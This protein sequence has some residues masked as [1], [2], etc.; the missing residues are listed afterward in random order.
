MTP[1]KDSS[2]TSTVRIEFW[3]LLSPETIRPV[4]PPEM[5]KTISIPASSRTRATSALA[6]I[7]SVSICSMAIESVLPYR[8]A[9]KLASSIG[10]RQPPCRRSRRLPLV[11]VG[12]GAARGKERQRRDET[13]HR[14]QGQRHLQ[15]DG[16]RQC[17]GDEGACGQSEQV[18]EQRQ[19]RC[20]GRPHAR[21]DDADNDRR[22][23]SDRAGRN[24]TAEQDQAELAG[25]RHFQAAM[26]GAKGSAGTTRVS[27]PQKR[28]LA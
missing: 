5:P 13:A 2:R 17:A 11:F 1:P 28:P 10:Q 16:V 18:L 20:P 14:R 6:G 26:P 19:H 15:P 3:Y 23:G 9:V 4:W 24:K 22:G 7:S 21:M 25:A 12:V 27:L 8:L